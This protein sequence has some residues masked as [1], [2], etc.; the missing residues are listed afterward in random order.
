M[1]GASCKKV[2]WGA[3]AP[4]SGRSPASERYLANL[5]QNIA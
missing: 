3:P 2:S 4:G 1:T 5:R